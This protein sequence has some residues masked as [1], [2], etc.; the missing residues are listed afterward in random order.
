MQ[1]EYCQHVVS[2]LAKGQILLSYKPDKPNLLKWQKHISLNEIKF[3]NLHFICN[4]TLQNIG[5]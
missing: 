4:L 1:H 3:W 2:R 5:T